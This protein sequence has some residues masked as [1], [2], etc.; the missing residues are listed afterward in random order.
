MQNTL[1]M[2]WKFPGMRES[3]VWK[4]ARI[5]GE[6]VFFTSEDGLAVAAVD[7][8]LCLVTLTVND[9]DGARVRSFD[10]KENLLNLVESIRDQFLGQGVPGAGG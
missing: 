4:I 6:A 10:A 9:S 8:E 2:L 3:H 1:T 7:T 5:D